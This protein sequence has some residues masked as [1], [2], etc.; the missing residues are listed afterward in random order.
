LRW[1]RRYVLRIIGRK[2]AEGGAY[3][4]MAALRKP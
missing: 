3:S 2:S 4:G 1:T